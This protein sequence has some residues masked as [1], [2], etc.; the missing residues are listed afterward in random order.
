MGPLAFTS[1]M[2]L[3]TVGAWGQEEFALQLQ[4]A[5]DRLELRW[6]VA[7]PAGESTPK[8]EVQRSLDCVH[9]TPLATNLSSANG[10]LSLTVVRD[11]Q[12]VFYRVKSDQTATPT[13]DGGEGVFGYTRSFKQ[14][15]ARLGY[16][17]T[18]DFAAMY[19]PPA[20]YL[21]RIDFDVTAAKYWTNVNAPPPAQF[22]DFRLNAAETARLQRNGFVASGRLGASCCLELYYNIFRRDLPVFITTDSILQA[23]HRSY[24]AILQDLETTYL[25]V[26]LA[27][28]LEGMAGQMAP[29]AQAY[30]AG[31]LKQ[32]VLDADYYL[33]V[34]RSLLAG[35][36]V[37]SVL[38]QDSAVAATLAG[39]E[40]L[41]IMPLNLFGRLD[42]DPLYLFDFSQFKPRGHYTNS[43]LLQRYFKAMMWCGRVDLRVA[44]NTNYASPRELGTAMS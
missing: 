7:V 2:G 23:W 24:D 34:A 31:E 28:M 42:K 35:A 21:D 25:S 40:S 44:G 1:A 37:P 39:V 4:S 11:G 41:S 6:E 18:A 27:A 5:G 30:G 15:L 22:P 32:S 26:S 29:L 14:Q 43:R 13:A 36:S 38:G 10:A 17:S 3:A 12:Q 19:P 16:L 20:D 9:W 8:F 33:A